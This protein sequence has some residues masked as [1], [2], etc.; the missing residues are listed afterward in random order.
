MKR[1]AV[2]GFAIVAVGLALNKL[3][4]LLSWWLNF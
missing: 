1:F 4:D 3:W 2:V